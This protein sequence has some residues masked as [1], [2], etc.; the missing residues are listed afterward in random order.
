MDTSH[1]P[2]TPNFSAVHSVTIARPL[3]EVFATL[4]T[5]S[6]HAAV[7]RLS[8]LCTNID[9]EQRD[10]VTLAP[11]ETL[12]GSSFIG[13]PEAPVGDGRGDCAH[14]Q[15]FTLEETV[16][17]LYGLLQSKIT[18]RGTLTWIQPSEELLRSGGPV[19]SV[20]ESQVVGGLGI[21][22]YRLREMQAIVTEGASGAEEVTEVT[23]YLYGVGP[24]YLKW[25][26]AK[27]AVTKHG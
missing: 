25:L 8:A 19:Y 7:C 1:L 24:S 21:K 22:I 3:A 26:I 16:P 13:K 2:F 15:H 11:G 6:A 27:E 18:V 20:Y 12:H 4:G 14:R 23:E 9:I 17:V 5:A 10:F